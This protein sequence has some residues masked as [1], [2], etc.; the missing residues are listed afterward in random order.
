MI[1]LNH[2]LESGRLQL[3]MANSRDINPSIA[4]GRN[5]SEIKI[6]AAM[7]ASSRMRPATIR[8]VYGGDGLR[9]GVIGFVGFGKSVRLNE[10]KSFCKLK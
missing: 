3:S 5:Q 1:V 6:Q 10:G 9:R 8:L 7:P 2:H 4:S